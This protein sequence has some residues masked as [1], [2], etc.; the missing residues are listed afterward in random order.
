MAG[1]RS[2]IE[3]VLA[4]EEA[5]TIK[6]QEEERLKSETASIEVVRDLAIQTENQQREIEISNENRQ[7][8]VAIETEKVERTKRMERVHSD[9]EVELTRI[10]ADKEVE[11]EKKNI[12][13]IIRE[14]VAVDKTV[15]IEEEKI[16]EVREVSEADRL[17][18]V[19][20]K[21]AEAVAE[22]QKV[23]EV[24]AAEAGELAAKH[25]A[26][27]I[28]TLA[29]A[30]LEAADKEARAKIKLAEGVRAEDAAGGL[31]EAEVIRATGESEADAT[32]KVGTSK[33]DV[34]LRQFKAEAEGLTEKFE[35]MN[36]MS[37]DA[38]SHEEFR[39]TIEIA[40][41]EALA[42]IDA[43]KEISKENAEVLATALREAK[44]DIVGG[45]GHF[46][47]T[48]AQSL[49]MGKAIDGLTQKSETVQSLLGQL[50]GYLNK[51]EQDKG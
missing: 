16:N 10:E 12:A 17:K 6:V 30:N 4:R 34:T 48:F 36:S 51:K 2:E 28:T 46:F 45:E 9:R 50:S 27:E 33:A 1:P 37:E 5:E 18:Q 35:A 31:A 24:K 32:L 25:Q 19:K 22:E 26:S 29:E 42:A 44:I 49:S 3:D 7:R 21:A 13:D 8:A 15:A 39:M 41:E 20:V 47:E 11:R 40:L 23:K 43:G 38:R 14:R